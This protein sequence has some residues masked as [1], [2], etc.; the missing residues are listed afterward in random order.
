M[1]LLVVDDSKLYQKATAKYFKELLPDAE[2]YFAL[3]GE[4][5][6]EMYKTIKPD[7]M[8]IDLLMPKMNGIE[9]LKAIQKEE[10]QVKLFVLSADVQKLVKEEVQTL[11]ATFINKP[12][13]ADKAAEIANIIKG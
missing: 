2:L 8:T 12:L 13:T 10:H 7:V 6:Y 9:L 4:Q 1:K 3:D 11:G 5:G